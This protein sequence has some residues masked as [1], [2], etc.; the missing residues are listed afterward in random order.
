MVSAQAIRNSL[1]QCDAKSSVP[2]V[3][4]QPDRMASKS[5]KES[6]G[7]SALL[8]E[9]LESLPVVCTSKQKNNTT[10]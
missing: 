9:Y 7:K 1:A 6:A 3:A 8:L 2:V 5:W 4:D 10:L